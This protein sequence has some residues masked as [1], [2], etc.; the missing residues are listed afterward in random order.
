VEAGRH[1]LTVEQGSLFLRKFMVLDSDGTQLDLTDKIIRLGVRQKK[2]AMNEVAQW[3]LATG[4][5]KRHIYLDASEIGAFHLRI[6]PYETLLLDWLTRAYYDL[7][8]TTFAADYD[9]VFA[10]SGHHIP[11]GDDSIPNDGTEGTNMTSWLGETDQTTGSGLD[12]IGYRGPYSGTGATHFRVIIDGTGANDT[13]EWGTVDASGVYTQDTAGINCELLASKVTLQDGIA[14]YFGAI[15][16]HT[17]S[18][19]WDFAVVKKNE[20]YQFDYNPGIIYPSDIGETAD[21]MA[22]AKYAKV[23]RHYGTTPAAGIRAGQSWLP[24]HGPLYVDSAYDPGGTPRESGDLTITGN[25]TAHF[26]HPIFREIQW[27][28]QASGSVAANADKFHWRANAGGSSYGGGLS[29]D[30]PWIALNQNVMDYWSATDVAMT[31][32]TAQHLTAGV[33]I[34]WANE[35]YKVG[36]HWFFKTVAPLISIT[37]SEGSGQHDGI[38]R[39]GQIQSNGQGLALTTLLSGNAET[40]YEADNDSDV[41]ASVKA[42]VED[43]NNLVSRILEGNFKVKELVTHSQKYID[44]RYPTFI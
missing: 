4:T 7:T 15:T 44:D 26:S 10:S 11:A 21:G 33:Y 19:A 39:V 22:A 36:D 16:G 34:N 31:K 5:N 2:M 20:A 29:E 13:F 41:T 12:D 25:L 8:L 30:S 28:C 17:L 38:Y 43:S 32:G 3:D 37:G 40:P 35:T 42:V 18:D 6:M 14:V 23:F 9:V 1:D 27:E 24:S